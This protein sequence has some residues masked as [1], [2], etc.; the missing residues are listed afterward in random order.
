MSVC[1]NDD[2]IFITNDENIL[3]VSGDTHTHTA[4]YHTQF[5]SYLYIM[6]ERE[7]ELI[8]HYSCMV[9]LTAFYYYL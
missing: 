1:G 2:P 6:V 5:S 8:E 9:F 4:V 7:F 3:F